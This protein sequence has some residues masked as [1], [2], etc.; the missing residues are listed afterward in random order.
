M[1]NQ[2]RNLHNLDVSKTHLKEE[3]R[4]FRQSLKNDNLI[5]QADK[6]MTLA[7][8]ALQFSQDAHRVAWET[9]V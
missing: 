3:L 1:T 6:A 2:A 4:R 9:A 8:A 7:N 5:N